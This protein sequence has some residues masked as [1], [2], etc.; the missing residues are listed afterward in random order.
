[1]SAIAVVGSL[2]MDLIVRLNRWPER[3]ETVLG[4]S[5]R[6]APGGKGANQA[7][8]AARQGSRVQMIGCVGQDRF[9]EGLL[10]S[11]R[12]AHVNIGGIREASGSSGVALIGIEPDGQGSIVVVPGANRAV[13]HHHIEHER[14][15]IA[16]S[17]YLLLQLEIP[18]EAN[19]AAAKLAKQ[20]GTKVILTPSP[21]PNFALPRELL[22]NVDIIVPNRGEAVALTGAD[23]PHDAARALLALGIPTVITTLSSEGALLADERG[24]RPIAPFAV[25]AVDS[26]A[27][28]DA[29]VGTLAAAL[30]LGESI[31]RAAQ[32]AAAAGAL[33]VTVL[34][35][36]PSL[37]SRQEV[38][39]LVAQAEGKPPPDYPEEMAFTFSSRHGEELL[40]RPVLPSDAHGLQIMFTELSEQSI[41]RRFL[42]L[43]GN[44][45][46]NEAHDYASVDYHDRLALVVTSVDA[47]EHLLAVARFAPTPQ[48]D[49]AVE[50]A[51]TVVDA[52]QGQGVGRTLFGALAQ[53]AQSLGHR[54]MLAETQPDNL[55]MIKLAEHAGYRY[56]V[57]YDG[58]LKMIWLDLQG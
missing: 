45:S 54:W 44:L 58:G 41:Y 9:A 33:A 57:T 51:I 28:G 56:E 20:L 26:T 16:E 53:A 43:R 6:T 24:I 30:A 1:M 25:D 5:F 27:A 12:S 10:E 22:D 3:D 40:V 34:G 4:R 48:R 19:I 8:A 21:I 18:I 49:N 47:P 55:R 13:S 37:P 29:F 11:L 46:N 23:T 14:R 42:S 15:R 50:M 31:D 38:D 7:V 2:N 32:R 35:A 17:Q 36:Q 52:Y 39:A